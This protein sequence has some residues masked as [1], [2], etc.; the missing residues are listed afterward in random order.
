MN[1]KSTITIIALS[2]MILSAG[3]SSEKSI[4]IKDINTIENDTI[5]NPK[6]ETNISSETMISQ[7]DILK[8]NSLSYSLNEDA[9][10]Y[11]INASFV[12]KSTNSINGLNFN[13]LI[14]GLE[15]D[16]VA[17]RL[18]KETVLPNEKLDVEFYID[19]KDILDLCIKEGE[20]KNIDNLEAI[21]DIHKSNR[22]LY[23]SYNYTYDNPM[24]NNLSINN[25]L[26]FDGNINQATLKI[27]D[28]PKLSNL[29]KNHN[30]NGS[31]LNLI[32]P[33][34]I[35]T[36][37]NIKTESIKVD[38]D[39]DLE[40]KITAKFKNIGDVKLD[41]FAFQPRLT[42]FDSTV[43]YGY[44]TEKDSVEPI[45]PQEEFSIVTTI[46]K[47][48]IV[49]DEN[50]ENKIDT[51]KS[52][53]YKKGDKL[54]RKLIKERLFSIGYSYHYKIGDITKSVHTLYDNTSELLEMN[55]F[56]YDREAN[57]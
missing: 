38:V 37:N 19:G 27:L 41:S 24:N 30:E 10:K 18:T 17:H 20:P 46:S 16:L 51:Y 23:L 26:D 43:S 28:N 2:S 48:D 34:D 49:F 54:L 39:E 6:R 47:D 42:L 44:S 32:E 56:E 1:K 9:T 57:D 35:N 50:I 40:F 53:K 33:E 11:K 55:L 52:L 15:Q 7:L 12:N 25:I 21:F 5:I 31:Y 36:F 4:K 22:S 8:L 29:P 13:F 3:C 45:E 14:C